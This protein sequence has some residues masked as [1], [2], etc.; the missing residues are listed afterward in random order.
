MTPIWQPKQ[1]AISSSNMTRF[2]SYI[3]EKYNIDFADYDELHQWSV[4]NIATFW[5]AVSHFCSVI[6]Q[7]EAAYC[8]VTYL[9]VM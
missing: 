5:K 8:C 2:C 1:E 3:K 6:Y 9:C 7:Q 4:D